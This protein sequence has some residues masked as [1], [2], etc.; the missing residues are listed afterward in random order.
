[1]SVTRKTDRVFQSGTSMFLLGYSSVL[2]L[3]FLSFRLLHRLSF[4]HICN[5]HLCLHW[6]CLLLLYFCYFPHLRCCFSSLFQWGP[7]SLRDITRR[8]VHAFSFPSFVFVTSIYSF[9]TLIDDFRN[10]A[11][12]GRSQVYWFQVSRWPSC[13]YW[14]RFWQEN[15]FVLNSE[16]EMNP[17]SVAT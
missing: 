17:Y 9:D 11:R 2:L 6:G 5:Y 12:R 13:K 10:Y 3:L 1:M 7:V 16:S 4:N 8:K 14:S 15:R